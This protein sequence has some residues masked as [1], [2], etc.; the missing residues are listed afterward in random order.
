MVEPIAWTFAPGG[1]YT[2][3]FQWLTDV[4]QAPTG[5][6][7]HRRLRISPRAVVGFSALESG[8]RRVWM[9]RQLRNHSAARW[10]VPVSIDTRY[11]AST[12]SAG[13]T[14][15]STPVAGA[16]FVAGGKVLVMG[17]DPRK[18]EVGA[19]SAVGSSSLTLS[20]GLAG[21]WPAGTQ[22]IPLRAGYLLEA[23]QVGRFTSQDSALVALRFRL[24]DALDTTAAMPG[25]TYRSYPVFDTFVPVWLSDPV[26]VPERRVALVDDDIATPLALDTAGVALGK[27]TMQYAPDSAADVA[28][29][30]AALFALA[31][32][33]SPAWVPS[34]AQ[35]LR[36][37]A[38]VGA[39]QGYIDVEG[40][41]LSDQPLAANRRDIRIEL[42][43]GTVHYRRI[44]DASALSGTVDRLTLDSTLPAA[45][46]LSDI[47]LVSFI[48]LSVLDADAVSLSYFDTSAAVCELVWRELDHDL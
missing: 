43:G 47:K 31:G 46:Q 21:G 42:F 3:E 26:W 1:E 13:A 15:L 14:V 25:A 11:L 30:R 38:G 4:L 7:Q 48:T 39:G 22:L 10:W 12:V 34:W 6:T 19:I 37:V 8:A 35:D 41:V 27:T 5:G 32:R 18:F 16:R 40:P 20:P 28:S 2:E 44:T 24:T 23:P 9:D 45:F 36:L 17:D 29:F 33:W